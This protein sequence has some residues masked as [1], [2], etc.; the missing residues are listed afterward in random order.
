M[1]EQMVDGGKSSTS[2]WM[3]AVPYSSI[4]SSHSCSTEEGRME[5]TF[6]TAAT[7]SAYKQS[8]F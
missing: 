3:M 4:R 8:I 5:Q 6:S 7:I 1:K 2:R